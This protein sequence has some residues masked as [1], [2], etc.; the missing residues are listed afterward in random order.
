[1]ANFI[2]PLNQILDLHQKDAKEGNMNLFNKN[3]QAEYS[4]KELKKLEKII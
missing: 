1:M 3:K 2:G 4:K